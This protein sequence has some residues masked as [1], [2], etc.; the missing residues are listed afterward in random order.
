MFLHA[1]LYLD[2][3]KMSCFSKKLW[4]AMKSGYCTIMW[5]RRDHWVSKVNH[6]QPHQRLVFIQRRWFVYGGIGKES[7]IM[8]S[9]QKTKQLIPT[10][11]APSCC[12]SHWV[13]SLCQLHGWL[14]ARF[15]CPVHGIF[16]ARIL[17]LVVISFRE[18][19]Q[20]RDRTCISCT[21][22]QIFY[23]WATREA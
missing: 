13:M 23:F 18:S 3:M 17:E 9:F 10:G 21:G 12:F 19:F 4:W 8:S 7:S 20:P 16:Q 1:V 6:H 22:R 15:L 14:P 2:V 11:A 5:N